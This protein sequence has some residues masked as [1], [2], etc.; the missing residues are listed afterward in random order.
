MKST[1]KNG[2]LGLMLRSCKTLSTAYQLNINTKSL[3]KK[4]KSHPKCSFS[5]RGLFVLKPII[6]SRLLVLENGFP[7]SL[8]SKSGKDS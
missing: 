2:R 8:T 3:N 5:L 4:K 1:S 6:I 7:T